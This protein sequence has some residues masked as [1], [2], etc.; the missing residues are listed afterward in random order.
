MPKLVDE[1][2]IREGVINRD[3]TIEI[4]NAAAAV[5][6]AVDENLDEFV[7]S[8]LSDLAQGAVVEREHIPLGTERVVC[9]Q[10]VAIDARRWTRD[11][12]LLGRRAKPPNIEIRNVLFERR[13]SK[14]SLRKP[15]CVSDKLAGFS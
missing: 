13:S 9:R 4:E 7:R 6:A 2:I 11:S 1:N 8:E 5:R 10:R 14:Q 12:R 15:A 3:R